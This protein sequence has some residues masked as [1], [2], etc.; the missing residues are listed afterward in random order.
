MGNF[1]T[2]SYRIYK[3]EIITIT[4]PDRQKGRCLDC[5]KYFHSDEPVNEG[6]CRRC[7]VINMTTSQLHN[8]EDFY[9]L[10][11]KRCGRCE[12]KFGQEYTEYN[13]DNNTPVFQQDHTECDRCHRKFHEGCDSPFD[14][15][16]NSCIMCDGC[17]ERIC[18][19]CTPTYHWVQSDLKFQPV[20]CNR[21]YEKV[22][23]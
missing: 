23:S 9:N 22:F 8:S 2:K 14:C 5:D 16:E 1:S 7:S 17:E 10:G 18:Y 12:G 4:L 20:W 21:C 19:L 13:R 6:R 11:E 15:D 3:K